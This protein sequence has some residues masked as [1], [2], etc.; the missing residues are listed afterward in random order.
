MGSRSHQN[1]NVFLSASNQTTIFT[2]RDFDSSA[3]LPGATITQSTI[4]NGSSVLVDTK[5]SDITGRAQFTYTSYT[6]YQFTV[7]L[8]GYTTQYFNLSPILFTSYNIR[9]QKIT[10]LSPASTPDFTS[11]SVSYYTSNGYLIFFNQANNTLY[12]I[13]TSP[14]GSLVNYSLNISTPNGDYLQAGNNAIGETF[15]QTFQITNANLTDRVK[16]SYCYQTTTSA[17]KCFRYPYLIEDVHSNRSIMGNLNQTY[18]MGV[19]ERTLIATV[20]NAVGSGVFYALGG[21]MAGLPMTLFLMVLFY[22]SGF[23]PLWGILPSMLV[24]IVLIIGGTRK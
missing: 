19:F 24:G 7:S 6:N 21:L 23:I 10:S 20:I 17:N 15:N 14:I 3:T 22:K 18:G 8:T 1:L 9:L 5:I 13:I 16:I 11:V 2:I 12:W 4:I